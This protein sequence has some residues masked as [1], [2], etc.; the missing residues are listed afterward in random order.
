M[1]GSKGETDGGETHKPETF[2]PDGHPDGE[3]PIQILLT[4]LAITS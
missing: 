4:R 2:Y 3:T 1:Y